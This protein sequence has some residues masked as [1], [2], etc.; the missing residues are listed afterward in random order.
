MSFSG[1]TREFG[2]L[3]LDSPI[4]SGNDDFFLMFDNLQQAAGLFI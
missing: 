2:S 4:K 1:L 3:V